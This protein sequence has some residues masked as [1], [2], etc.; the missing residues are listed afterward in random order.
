MLSLQAEA[1][2]VWATWESRRVIR[3]ID[4]KLQQ[5]RK[6][7]VD[8]RSSKQVSPISPCALFALHSPIGGEVAHIRV[9]RLATTATAPVERSAR[10]FGL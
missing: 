9:Q 2:P 1:E 10:A 7:V 8:Q 3:Q 5:K 6:D 4:K